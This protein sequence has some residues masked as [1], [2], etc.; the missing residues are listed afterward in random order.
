MGVVLVVV[1]MVA[2]GCRCWGF[3]ILHAAS[4]AAMV[5]VDGRQMTGAVRGE[6]VCVCVGERVGVG[7]VAW[8]Q[9]RKAGGSRH[10][11]RTSRGSEESQR[12]ILLCG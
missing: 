4:Q 11:Y 10:W 3:D 8:V 7:V 12:M 9:R 2:V 5:T 1:V 6:G